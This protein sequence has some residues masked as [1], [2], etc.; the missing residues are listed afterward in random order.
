MAEAPADATPATTPGATLPLEGA[1]DLGGWR[2]DPATGELSRGGERRRL[3]PKVME[4]LVYLAAR[5]GRVVAQEELLDR[6][7][8]DTVVGQDSLWRC[9]GSLR[10]ALGDDAR[11]PRFIE[12]RPKRGYRIRAPVLPIAG[13][14]LAAG[15]EPAARPTPTR[16]R[17]P[18]AAKTVV[19]VAAV[20]A[21]VAAV[22]VA[23]WWLGRPAKPPHVS[24]AAPAQT[25]VPV[26]ADDFYVLANRYYLRFGD[27]DLERAV[28]LYQRA[29]GLDPRHAGAWA[30][31]ADVHVQWYDRR[32]SER[33]LLDRAEAA[34][35]RAVELAPDLAHPHKSRGLVLQT[36]GALRSAAV[37]YR[38]ALALDPELKAAINNLASIDE[39]TGDLPAAFAGFGKID[40]VTPEIRVRQ[41]GNLGRVLYLAGETAAAREHLESAARIDPFHPLTV[42]S[43]TVLDLI[44]GRTGAARERAEQALRIHPGERLCHTAAGLA[45]WTG[46]DPVAAR[47][48]FERSLTLGDD[49]HN[50]EAYLALGVLLAEEEPER[51]SRLLEGLL[52]AAAEAR[53]ADDQRWFLPLYAA[54]AHAHLGDPDAAGAAF[55]H[56]LELGFL[57]HRWL[58]ADPSFRALAELPPIRTHLVRLAAASAEM[59]A[60]ITAG[61]RP[62]SAT[63][64]R[65]AVLAAP[66]QPPRR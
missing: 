27:E 35:E 34:A 66:P 24:P 55:D 61:T 32:P 37:E 17:P 46:G 49:A 56:A 62:R 41:L 45:A 18:T 26:S 59:G 9:I 40:P 63:A 51:S 12:T 50:F 38:R 43:L 23:G 1:F 48:H 54:G 5:P 28:E 25:R 13:A 7:W 3:E 20:V 16:R 19:A 29:I 10:Q 60:R 14:P 15:A 65:M 11:V 31:I 6:V 53:R 58:A 36:R 22:A 57:D 52:A 4:V 33:E 42:Y 44:E 47:A 30:G 64:S 39:I 21:A 2:V 8:P